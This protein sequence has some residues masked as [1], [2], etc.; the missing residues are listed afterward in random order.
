MH[1]NIGYTKKGIHMKRKLLYLIATVTCMA[2]L[3]SACG[4][5]EEAMQQTLSEDDIISENEISENEIAEPDTYVTPHP[6][7]IAGSSEEDEDYEDEDYE[8]DDFS[9]DEVGE[10]AESYSEDDVISAYYEDELNPEDEEIPEEDLDEEWDE[11]E[12]DYEEEEVDYSPVR[13]GSVDLN[14]FYG[15]KILTFHI[16]SG[17]IYYP[18]YSEEDS[19]YN[20]MDESEEFDIY[21]ENSFD[22][23]Y[24]EI[25]ESGQYDDDDNGFYDVNV[26]TLGT[27]YKG[28]PAYA[29]EFGYLDDEDGTFEYD[30]NF[31]IMP[32]VDSEGE[33]DYVVIEFNCGGEEYSKGDYE[34][35]FNNLFN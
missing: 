26:I 21:I 19:Y 23:E 12:E 30:F 24:R 17:L 25:Y 27:N 5:Q 18:E 29:V 35:L 1:W 7:I 2:T 16:P 15:E 20:L 14:D 10:N 13:S 28:T 11:D 3:L 31:I 33:S 34:K 32:Y 9:D 8:E 4:E 22:E 6:L